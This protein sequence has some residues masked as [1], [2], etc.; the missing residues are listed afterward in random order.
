M[1]GAAGKLG[2][3]L[4][5]RQNHAEGNEVFRK[6]PNQAVVRGADLQ[7][8]EN[9]RHRE[10][11]PP[12]SERD[13]SGNYSRR[14]PAIMAPI[15]DSRNQEKDTD[16]QDHARQRS[17]AYGPEHRPKAKRSKQQERG[18]QISAALLVVVHEG[19]RHQRGGARKQ[20]KR[21]E[22][23][24]VRKAPHDETRIEDRRKPH[25]ADKYQTLARVGINL[26]YREEEADPTNFQGGELQ[27]IDAGL[28]EP[29]GA[30]RQPRGKMGKD[31]D[32]AYQP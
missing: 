2:F 24:R 4:K 31:C 7:H 19:L 25:Q 8:R 9:L 18:V 10:H 16:E 13:R 21:A 15:E 3:V 28:G 20:Q 22:Y 30:Y 32:P 5:Q 26:R 17:T 1:S 14:C 27:K 29:F 23:S 11:Q 6:V 12:R